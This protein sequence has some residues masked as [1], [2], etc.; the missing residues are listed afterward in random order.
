M[1]KGAWLLGNQTAD[2]YRT[3][4]GAIRANLTSSSVTLS[5]I[6]SARMDLDTLK[7]RIVDELSTKATSGAGAAQGA[8]I[9]APLPS[10]LPCLPGLALLSV[11]LAAGVGKR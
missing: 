5:Q 1:D 10:K 7:L 2:G 3:E 8:G 9:P 4:L 6:S 11:L